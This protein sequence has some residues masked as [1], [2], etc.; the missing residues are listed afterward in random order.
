MQQVSSFEDA[1]HHHPMH[2]I[3][4]VVWLCTRPAALSRA[5][6]FGRPAVAADGVRAVRMVSAVSGSPFVNNQPN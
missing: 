2:S 6:R 5:D 4:T 3:F 1:G